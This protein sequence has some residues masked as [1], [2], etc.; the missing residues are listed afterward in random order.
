MKQVVTYFLG[1]EILTNVDK[2]QGYG[3]SFNIPVDA[4]TEDDSWLH[5]YQNAITEIAE[6]FKPDVHF[7]SKRS[8]FPLLRSTNTSLVNDEIL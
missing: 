5:C 2:E 1:Q 4:F 3:Y 8:R 6:F 7:N